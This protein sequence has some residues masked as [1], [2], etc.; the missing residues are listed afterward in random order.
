MRGTHLGLAEHDGAAQRVGAQALVVGDRG[1]DGDAASADSLSGLARARR[2]ISATIS[3]MY[4]GTWTAPAC[5]RTDI[6]L[7]LHD[8]DLVLD[9]ARVVGADLGAEAVLQRRDDAAA[10]GVV[11]RVGAG[12]DAH[13]ERQADA[14]AADL[15]VALFHD[16]EQADLDALGEVGQ[17][18]D[19]EDAAIGARDQAVVDRQL[20]GEVAALGDLDRVDL[21]DQVG[22]RD[23]RRRQLLAVAASREPGDAGGIAA[24]RRRYRGRPA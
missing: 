12:D 22:D 21:A 1:A 11:L 19:A 6:A 9:V 2:V 5:R 24:V 16:V 10:V 15:D 8:V 13:V 7:L 20:V 4:C 14:V 23:V 18:V 17:L 3:F